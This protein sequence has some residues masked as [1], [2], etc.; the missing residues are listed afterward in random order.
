MYNSHN[1]FIIIINNAVII[2]GHTTIPLAWYASDDYMPTP[3]LGEQDPPP[4]PYS[5]EAEN[6]HV[7]IMKS[8]ISSPNRNSLDT[9]NDTL[10]FSTG[11][12][13]DMNERS[14]MEL[15]NERQDIR[16]V[17]MATNVPIARD[18]NESTTK[19]VNGHKPPSTQIPQSS[20]LPLSGQTS[21]Q[22]Q[23]PRQ[24]SLCNPSTELPPLSNQILPYTHRNLSR[25]TFSQTLLSRQQQIQISPHTHQTL[26]PLCRTLSY[27]QTLPQPNLY[28]LPQLQSTPN[29]IIYQEHVNHPT[30]S[31]INSPTVS[32]INTP[33]LTSEQITRNKR[34]QKRKKSRRRRS[35]HHHSNHYYGNTTMTNQHVTPLLID[36]LRERYTDSPNNDNINNTD[37]LNTLEKMLEQYKFSND[38]SDHDNSD[39]DNSNQDNSN[40]TNNSHDNSNHSNLD[41]SK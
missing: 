29:Q 35:H 18:I 37:E 36:S 27:P 20:Q 38:K 39:H 28:R 34:K 12:P 15:V 9:T 31:S 41:M 24:I 5:E 4:P 33:S 30:V 13:I 11:L 3:P 17:S 40:H 21:V 23:P 14:T 8:P 32:S 26:P 16:G 22:T 7:T 2:A 10:S 6:G 25:Q 1:I 19:Q